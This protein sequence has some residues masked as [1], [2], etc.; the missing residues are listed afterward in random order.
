VR[1]EPLR[2]KQGKIV[3]WYGALDRHRRTKTRREERERC[4]DWNR[5]W[6]TPIA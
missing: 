4:E 1:A 6:R 3:K 2:D 5:S